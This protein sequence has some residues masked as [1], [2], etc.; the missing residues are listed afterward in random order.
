MTTR[1][2]C[3]VRHAD[4]DESSNRPA[5]LT[6]LTGIFVA[7]S[8]LGSVIA[9]VSIGAAFGKS[10]GL[11]TTVL[12]GLA[13]LYFG[14]FFSVPIGLLFGLPT[15][16]VTRR[17][18]P[19]YILPVTTGSAILGLLGGVVLIRLGLNNGAEVNANPIFGVCVGVMH[20]LVYSRLEKASWH[21]ICS[22]SWW[23]R[24]S[25]LPGKICT[26]RC[27]VRRITRTDASVHTTLSHT[28]PT[29]LSCAA[30]TELCR[31]RRASG[32]GIYGGVR[33]TP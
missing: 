8:L 25:H 30:R 31:L 12:F 15:L 2:P 24:A 9:A 27:R 21:S 7:A 23:R 18:L 17:L 13:T 33:F 19:R 6:R 11:T 20:P 4:M 14:A 5:N 10:D 26:T 3:R 32:N 22:A 29:G 1:A 16:A 28:S